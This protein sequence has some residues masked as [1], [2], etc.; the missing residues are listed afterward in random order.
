MAHCH[1]QTEHGWFLDQRA[2]KE[3]QPPFDKDADRIQQ[4]LDAGHILPVHT[5]A[6][7]D[8][9]QTIKEGWLKLSPLE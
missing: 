5:Q 8:P 3:L 1:R 2:G 6:T 4:M 9:Q 7:F